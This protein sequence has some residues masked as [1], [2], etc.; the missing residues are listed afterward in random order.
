MLVLRLGRGA[1]TIDVTARVSDWEPFGDDGVER[2]LVEC[3]FVGK[4]VL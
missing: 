4:V 3:D 1:E 2:Y